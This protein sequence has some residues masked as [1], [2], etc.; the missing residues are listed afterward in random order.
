LTAETVTRRRGRPRSDASERAIVAAAL[1]LLAEGGGHV[2]ITEIARRAG[3]GKDTVYRRWRSKDDLLLDALATLP[4]PAGEHADGPIREVLIARL[5]ELIERLH[6]PRNE[7]IYRA[8]FGG[9]PVLRE[10]F[11]AEVI[12]PRRAATR[13][14]IAAAIRRGELSADTDPALLGVM[15]FAPVLGESLEGRPRAPLRGA[16]REVATRLVDAVLRGL[17]PPER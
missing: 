1:E 5:S 16:P 9:S 13:R 11:F 14:V 2:T 12:E 7:R 4:G 6:E 15:L 3:V 10:R 17:R 8:V